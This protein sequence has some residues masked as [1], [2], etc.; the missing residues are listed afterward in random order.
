ME[1]IR[2]SRGSCS[3]FE[4]GFQGRGKELM[5]E[6]CLY[7]CVCLCRN[8]YMYISRMS[9]SLQACSSSLSRP[10]SCLASS[11]PEVS[12][13]KSSTSERCLSVGSPI[14]AIDAF[15]HQRRLFSQLSCHLALAPTITQKQHEQ[16]AVGKASFTCRQVCCHSTAVRRCD[17][18]RTADQRE[19]SKR[20]TAVLEK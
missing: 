3:S 18:P 15:P 20:G 11:T 17:L 5:H 7:V 13:P 8:D 4:T 12:A 9:S 2:R 1:C 6:S 10:E 19:S 14:T 16:S